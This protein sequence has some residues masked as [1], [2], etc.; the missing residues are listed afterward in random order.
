MRLDRVVWI[1][2]SPCAGKTL[3]ARQVADRLGCGVYAV[4]ELEPK[5][6][7]DADAGRYPAFARWA[8]MSLDERWVGSTVD[9]LVRDSIE[10]C[11][12]IFR[13]VVTD[14]AAEPGPVVV[15]GFQP[16]PELVGDVLPTRGHAVFLV[17]TPEFR[18]KM[19]FSRPHAWTTPSRTS[20]PERAQENRLERDDRVA[21][22]IAS[23][24]AERK[25]K[26]I[27]V[28]GSRSLDEVAAEAEGHLALS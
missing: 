18:R 1:A 8:S 12:D 26:T 7:R 19:H 2:G 3:L 16:L 9:E 20:D 11:G 17:A 24:A 5:T 10:L 13:F 6:L 15:E 21:E 14:L 23:E 27:I 22:H 25:L 4:D 28:D